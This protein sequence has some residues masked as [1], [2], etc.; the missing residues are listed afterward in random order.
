MKKFLT[1]FL[2]IGT[3]L[4]FPTF[5]VE[6]KAQE[7][8]K[9]AVEVVKTPK[10]ALKTIK[11]VRVAQYTK[12][13]GLPLELAI[14][15]SQETGIDQELIHKI[16]WAE[17]QYKLDA[18]GINKNGSVDSGLFQINSQHIPLAKSMGIDIFTPEGNAEFAIYLIKKN[19]LRDWGYSKSTWNML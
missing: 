8:P 16:M 5:L 15:V 6:I 14:K 3:L 19:G 13:Q 10:I 2:F 11:K 7:A 18:K 17:S 9:V 12:P 4:C 1:V